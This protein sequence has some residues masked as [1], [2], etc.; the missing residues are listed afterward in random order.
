[1]GFKGDGYIKNVEK[2]ELSNTT[3]IGRSFN[4]KD[5]AGLKTVAL[6]SEK[7]IEVKN[8]A[9]IV[10]V[11]LT[12]LKADKFSIDAMY[13][14]KVLDSASGVKDTQNLKVN[15][16]GA[17][18]K[19]VALTAEKIEVLNLNTIGEASFLKDVNVENVSVK[20]SANLSL[21]TGLK[22]TT[23]DASS[24]GGA[25]DADLSASD[26]LNT[27][28]GGNGNDKITIGTNV[29]NVNVDGGAGNDELVIKSSTAGTLQP[30][31]T[32]IEKVTIDGNTADLTL[33]LKKAESV[34]ELS[35]ANLAKKVTESNGNVDT[36]NFLAGNS[37]ASSA[38]VTI[39][40]ATLKTI[41]FV[42]ADKAVKGNIAADKATEL[43][44][45]SGKVEAA[46]DAVV[47]AASA[48][49]ISINAAKDTA[50]LTLTAGKLTDLTVN[51]KG[52]FELVGGVAGTL[53]NVENLT[54]ASEGK[55]SITGSTTLNKVGNIAL[56]GKEIDLAN[57]NIGSDTLSSLA[58]E[59]SELS[60]DL[61]L[62]STIKAKGDINVN[63]NSIN[64]ATLGNITS[65]TGNASVIISSATGAVKLGT[66]S[67]VNG[68]VTLNA[69]DASTSVT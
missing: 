45:N 28:K 14:N 47:T 69:G 57:Q 21:T 26:K 4:A 53:N 18:D 31:L 24:F 13:A 60:G 50:G 41:N 61:K 66:V 6:N 37:E 51:N 36:V 43:T 11:E 32:N 30:T 64:T 65:S 58:V 3:S 48:T 63:L 35:F 17:K 9:N 15:G 54:V 7:G 22:T 59:V 25:L 67:A 62:G 20:G 42:D 2:L 38:Q 49:N 68:N 5:V 27:V 29:A 40:D 12:N 19:A 56:S 44:I 33:S 34:T 23:L 39:S 10:D 52:D 55:F 8:L 1:D 46:A 16:V